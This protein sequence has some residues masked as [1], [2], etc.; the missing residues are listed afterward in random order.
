MTA[1]VE[2]LRQR[3]SQL[4]RATVSKTTL[5][6]FDIIGIA[7]PIR[8]LLHLNEVDYDLIQVS[9][10]EW[11]RRDDNNQQPLKKA[12]KNGHLPYYVDPD[13]ELNQSNSI[14]TYLAEQHG[15]MGQSTT[16]RFAIL[17]VM[18][19]AYDALFHWNGLLQTVIRPGIEDEVV[20]ARMDAFMGNRVWGI[21]TNGYRNHLDGFRNYLQ[22][23]PADSGF[24]V[25]DSLTV[26]DLHAFNLLCNW[27]K[28]FDPALFEAEY[29]DLD[30]CIRQIARIPGVRDYIDNH[31]EATVWFELPQVADRFT[32][33]EEL[34]GLV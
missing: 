4:N 21:V 20:K 32:T 3:I 1:D 15:F 30:A 11:S 28:A 34:Q 13:I 9:I 2:A 33:R 6:Y 8:C 18:A 14:L 19:H 26:A 22:S 24:F 29:P 12:L 17:E 23:N 16:E 10:A 5:V 27:Y 25:G 7:W 31:Q